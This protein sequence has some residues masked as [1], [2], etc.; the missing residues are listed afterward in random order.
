MISSIPVCDLSVS[1]EHVSQ[2]LDL[3]LVGSIGRSEKQ[4]LDLIY[5]EI[6]REE[7][8]RGDMTIETRCLI[9]EM[10]FANALYVPGVWFLYLQ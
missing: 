9:K 2:V 7:S 1:F 8:N 4:Y 6:F 5:L 10:I 3:M